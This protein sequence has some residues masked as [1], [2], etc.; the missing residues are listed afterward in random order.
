M[1]ASLRAA[2]SLRVVTVPQAVAS[3]PVDGAR[4]AVV[5]LQVAMVP[6]VA[7]ALHLVATVLRAVVLLQVAMVPQVVLHLVAT[8]LPAAALRLVVTVLRVAVVLHL[9]VTVLR[10]AVLP[11]ACRTT[12]LR[13]GSRLRRISPV[14]RLPVVAVVASKPP[15][16]SL[17]VGMR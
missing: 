11:A 15:R 2:A 4:L 12:R 10:A 7:V 1:A 9:V 14:P 16:R 13:V 3:L 17:S 6:R 8:V 5:L